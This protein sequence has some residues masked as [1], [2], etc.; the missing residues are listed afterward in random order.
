MSPGVR[1]PARNLIFGAGFLLAVIALGVGGYRA[2]GWNFNDAIYMVVITVA[3]VGYEEVHPINTPYLRDLT[4]AVI[5]LGSTGMIFMTGALV[6]LFTAMQIQQIFGI[7]RMKSEID[8]LNDHVIVCGYG[9]IGT[10][11]LRELKAARASFVMLDRSE[12]KIAEARAAGILCMQGDAAD[13]ATLIAAG[14]ERAR[15]LATVL[16]DDAANVFITLS[17]RSLNKK[18]Q[19]IARGEMPATEGKLIHAGADLVVLPTHIGAERIAEMIL[20]QETFRFLRSEKMNEFER[21]LRKLGLEIEVITAAASGPFTGLTVDEI[22]RRAQGAFL[23]VGINRHD[24]S[25]IHRPAGPTII[26]P[27]DGLIILGRSGRMGKFE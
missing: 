11:L 5:I 2:A 6:Q 9:R 27:G 12:Q 17:A 10:K 19:I 3:T 14:I 7:N 25:A 13:E 23:V 16:P 15:T 26:N 21:D 8:R 4:M 24:G 18:L 20:Y 22:D 1:Q